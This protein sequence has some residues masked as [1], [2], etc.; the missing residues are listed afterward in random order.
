MAVIVIGMIGLMIAFVRLPLE[1][2]DDVSEASV[3]Q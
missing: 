3:L 2:F 1:R